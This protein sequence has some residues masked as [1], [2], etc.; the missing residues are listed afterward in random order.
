MTTDVMPSYREECFIQG[1]T[2]N[3]DVCEDMIVECAH[4]CAVIDGVTS[5][6]GR[7]YDGKTG[8]RLAAEL[9]AQEIRR[10]D[11]WETAISALEK[12]DLAVR[13][14]N[15]SNSKE[16]D[17]SVQACVIL[18]SKARREVWNY[19][20]CNCMIN[21]AGVDH[22]KQVDDIL[23]RL[24][25]L[26]IA[27]HLKQGGKEEDILQRDI[28]RE[29]IL[30]FLKLQSVF[31]ND[32]SCFGYPVINGTGIREQFIK[33]YP[34]AVGDHVVLASDGYPKL[35]PTLKESEEYLQYILQAD[36]LA[37]L[38]NVQTKMLTKGNLSFDDR[39][40]LSFFVK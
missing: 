21:G 25:A 39:A 20:D 32:D 3:P 37:Y 30:P 12:L 7:L 17:T 27:A 38:E 15:R 36:P 2:G 9:L 10:F 33:C 11:P 1:K 18:Y 13:E 16:P 5:K 22:G 4:F 24:R 31:A 29:A 6:T 23:G 34:V 35:F 28:G 40:Y 19:G 14:V 26:V 8:G